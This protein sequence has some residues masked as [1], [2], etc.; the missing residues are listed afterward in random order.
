[1][2]DDSDPSVALA[3][4]TALGRIGGDPIPLLPILARYLDES[5]P[6]VRAA[7]EA[8]TA[9]GEAA[10]PLAVLLPPLLDM[11]D[12]QGW[13]QLAVAEAAWR[14]TGRP[15]AA[16]PVFAS[17]WHRSLRTRPR[18]ADRLREMTDI[19]PAML[20]EVRAEAALR[21]RH[22]A[23]RT[24]SASNDIAVDEAL[25]RAC[26]AILGRAASGDGADPRS[27]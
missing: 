1:L 11:P 14:S 15:D 25:L 3:A 24:T 7:A 20:A 18:I 13:R 22:T 19:D 8:V 4:V 23:S 21:R 27:E 17:V 2:C 9:I 26:A 5:S 6:N 10:A 16:I 12:P